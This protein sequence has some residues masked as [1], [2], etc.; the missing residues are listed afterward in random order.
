V[1]AYITILWAYLHAYIGGVGERGKEGEAGR[2][3]KGAGE[4]IGEKGSVRK[5]R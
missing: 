1:Q 5:L 4:K 2:R 3:E